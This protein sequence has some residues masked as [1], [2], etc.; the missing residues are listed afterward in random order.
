IAKHCATPD[1]NTFGTGSD[2][3]DPDGDFIVDEITE[4]QLTAMAVYMGLRETPVRVP[5]TSEPARTRVA[6]GE[7]LFGT[8]GCGDCHV[9]RM[10]L[11]S[12]THVEPADTT[13]GAGITFNLANDMKTPHPGRNTDGSMTVELWSDFK[14]HDMGSTLADGKPFKNIA[15]SQF[16]TTPLWGVATSPP[17]LH[18]GRA[19]TL[20]EAI[21]AHAGEALGSRVAFAAL[22]EDDQHKIIDF[23]NTLGR[24]E[25]TQL[26][27]S[28][29]V[30]VSG[31]TVRQVNA[32]ASFQL[33]AGT[34]V[35]HGGYVIVA[36]S[37]TKQQ[38]ELFY[39][40]TLA[41]NVTFIN[42]AG[43]FPQINGS[44]TFSLENKQG[45]LIEGP[46]IAQ[47]S[48]GL[49][50]FQRT[51]A[52]APAGDR[53]SWTITSSRPQDANP[54]SGQQTTGSGR[55]YLSEIADASG[56]G[57]F[58]LEFVELFVE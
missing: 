50:I 4:G 12:P 51:N 24:E 34:V 55:I 28:E 5:V 47:A 58:G 44:E 42:S 20:R 40:R 57:N 46:T 9:A 18:D 37:A 17:Y 14:R 2:C 36:R 21:L 22:S 13:G 32:A 23:L 56:T 29:G 31:F 39:Q 1:T 3:K 52:L 11:R 19:P 43:K 16:L 45:F 25:T 54:G 26:P 8:V 33:P 35:P 30:D 15:P 27:L 6:A 10:Q 49:Q 48:A 41:D 7:Q 38:F 53:A